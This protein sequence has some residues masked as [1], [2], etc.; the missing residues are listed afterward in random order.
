MFLNKRAAPLNRKEEEKQ[1][2]P[3]EKDA[4]QHHPT[5]E[6]EKAKEEK[7]SSTTQKEEEGPHQLN[8]N[9][10]SVGLGKLHSENELHVMK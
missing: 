8:R 9:Q 2:H 10:T 5:R 1:C 7:E 3:K 4:K 6:R